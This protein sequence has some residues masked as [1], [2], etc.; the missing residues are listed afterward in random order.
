MAKS[1][2]GN[3][4]EITDVEEFWPCVDCL[5]WCLDVWSEDGRTWVREC[6]DPTCPQLAALMKE[7]SE[8]HN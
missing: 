7:D 1:R 4:W 6:H 5:T 3:V 8:G 2:R